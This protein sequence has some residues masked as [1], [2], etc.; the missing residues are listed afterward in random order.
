MTWIRTSFPGH[1]WLDLSE[2]KIAVEGILPFS[3]VSETTT[4]GTLDLVD[5]NA[6]AVQLKHLTDV[7]AY[8]LNVLL[9]TRIRPE[10]NFPMVRLTRDLGE[11]CFP[12]QHEIWIT[13]WDHLTIFHLINS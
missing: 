10:K 8:M 3:E 13:S 2:V 6:E 9:I 1:V 11:I 4:D 7:F 5:Q 12:L